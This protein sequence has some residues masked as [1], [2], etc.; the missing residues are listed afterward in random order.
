MST[1]GI[2]YQHLC[3]HHEFAEAPAG[4]ESL[5]KELEELEQEREYWNNRWG[6]HDERDDHGD[7]ARP[8]GWDRDLD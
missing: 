2:M 3:A 1:W 7:P 6:E 8:H 5:T 4:I